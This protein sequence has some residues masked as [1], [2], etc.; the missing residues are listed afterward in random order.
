MRPDRRGFVLPTTLMVMTLL[1]VMLTAAFIMI[2]AEFRTSDN[3]L[4][5]SRANA[6][7]QAGLQ[8]YL[9]R[10]RGLGV[11]SSWDSLRITYSAGYV[12][13]VGTRLVAAVGS[14]PALWVVRSTA[15]LTAN[16]LTGTTTA[17]STV[18]QLTENSAGTLPVKGAFAAGNRVN[19]TGGGSAPISGNDGCNATPD[20]VEVMAAAIDM[21]NTPPGLTTRNFA[22]AAVLDSMHVDWASLLAGNFA[23]DYTV[24]AWPA[25]WTGWPTY[26]SPGDLTFSGARNGILV[27]RGNLTIAN[28][29][30]WAGVVIVGG[31]LV[32]PASSSPTIYGSAMT[33]LNNLI[34]PGSV[35]DDTIPRGGT[36]I[37]WNSCAV[38]LAVA[39]MVGMTPVRH[40]FI[41]T[42]AP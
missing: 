24:P 32:A 3:S 10:N 15:T 14:R 1:T 40:A 22:R 11:S 35:T 7:A 2:S 4:A 29:A 5:M 36:A 6:L 37:S 23:A 41:D 26:Y 18:A 27:V 30:L 31:R 9:S 8:D 33:G 20:T 42:W 19:F 13:V 28:G 21:I 17:T 25:S 39:G 34:T 38:A 16:A 12:D